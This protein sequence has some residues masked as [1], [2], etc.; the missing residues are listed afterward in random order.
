MSDNDLRMF[1][2]QPVI[3][4]NTTNQKP[5]ETSMRKYDECMNFKP[6][7]KPPTPRDEEKCEKKVE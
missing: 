1:N 4:T 2:E 6:V 7:I 3:H 5:E